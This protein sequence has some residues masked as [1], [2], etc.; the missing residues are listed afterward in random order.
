M[1][2]VCFGTFDILQLLVA[3][4]ANMSMNVSWS[5]TSKVG[6]VVT[7]TLM[8]IEIKNTLSM[9]VQ[10]VMRQRGKRVIYH[11]WSSKLD[12]TSWRKSNTH[13]Y[14]ITLAINRYIEAHTC[15]YVAWHVGKYDPCAYVCM[16]CSC[17][18][19]SSYGAFI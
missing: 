3:S 19:S 2:V 14:V 18:A 7:A 6:K 11:Y 10:F 9:V 4:L 15:L 17:L 8:W 16:Y 12:Q 5:A 1:Y 13:V